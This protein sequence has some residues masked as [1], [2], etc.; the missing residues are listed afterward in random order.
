MSSIRTRI[1]GFRTLHV[2]AVVEARSCSL[3]GIAVITPIED[4]RA[5]DVQ[6]AVR[7]RRLEPAG[8]R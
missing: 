1:T 8:E 2:V 6:A 3:V 4:H 7:R 5:K